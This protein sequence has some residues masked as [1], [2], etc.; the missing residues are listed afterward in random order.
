MSTANNL[1][2]SWHRLIHHPSV[3]SRGLARY[4]APELFQECSDWLIAKVKESDFVYFPYSCFLSILT[5]TDSEISSWLQ[6]TFRQCRRSLSRASPFGYVHVE[7]RIHVSRR[8][9]QRCTPPLFERPC[10]NSSFRARFPWDCCMLGDNQQAARLRWF[11]SV[12][13]GRCYTPDGAKNQ[14]LHA[15]NPTLWTPCPINLRFFPG[16]ASTK[17][18]NHR[19]NSLHISQCSYGYPTKEHLKQFR[20]KARFAQALL[21]EEEKIK[22]TLLLPAPRPRCTRKHLNWQSTT[23]KYAGPCIQTL[24]TSNWIAINSSRYMQ[25]LFLR[26]CLSPP[27]PPKK[28]NNRPTGS[29]VSQRKAHAFYLAPIIIDNVPKSPG[30]VEFAHTQPIHCHG[31]QKKN[32]EHT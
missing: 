3:W 24:F 17:L 30:Q 11:R 2:A 22:T 8:Y 31:N 13:L 4:D 6:F 12:V 21:E 29:L 9:W 23:Q 27:P 25:T 5:R 19:D 15:E 1:S 16:I 28:M 14:Y 7:D 10:G 26:D 20:H 18:P 32:A